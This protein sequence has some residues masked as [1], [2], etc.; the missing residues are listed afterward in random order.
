MRRPNRRHDC[1]RRNDLVHKLGALVELYLARF[2]PL[3]FNVLL[4]P[5]RWA[6]SSSNALVTLSLEA[7]RL[8]IGMSRRVHR[9]ALAVVDKSVH[10][11]AAKNHRLLIEV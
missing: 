3:G 7:L 9:E 5:L 6:G 2:C 11:D 10:V 1:G 4:I 8:F